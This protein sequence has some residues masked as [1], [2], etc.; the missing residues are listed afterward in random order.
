MPEPDQTYAINLTVD[1]PGLELFE[2]PRVR[3]L[4]VCAEDLGGL[5]VGIEAV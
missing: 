2:D 5:Q 4:A 1:I 3:V